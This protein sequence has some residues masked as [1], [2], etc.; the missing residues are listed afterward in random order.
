MM[1]R[2]S[3]AIACYEAILNKPSASPA[4]RSA[5]LMHMADAQNMMGLLDEAYDSLERSLE[6][7]S[8][9]LEA[10]YQLV[11]VCKERL[12]WEGNGWGALVRRIEDALR[13]ATASPPPPPPHK[14]DEEEDDYDD[15]YYEDDADPP[16]PLLSNARPPSPSDPPRSVHW[17]LFEACHR[18][19]TS[20]CPVF[21]HALCA[22]ASRCTDSSD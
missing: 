1:G 11:Q 10:Y 22:H 20:L 7:D 15:Y 12:C 21:V 9:N 2:G 19:G 3:E 14:K 13:V 5:G 4:E 6:M 17:A 18:A 8:T 16:P